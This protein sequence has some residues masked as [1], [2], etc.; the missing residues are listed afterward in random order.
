MISFS[1]TTL[2][3]ECHQL[4]NRHET[5]I[6]KGTAWSDGDFEIEIGTYNSQQEQVSTPNPIVLT[7]AQALVLAHAIQSHYGQVE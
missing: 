5:Q 4:L 2:V 7:Q 3:F 1:E 6:I